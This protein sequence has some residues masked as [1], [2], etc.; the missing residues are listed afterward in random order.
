MVSIRAKI[1]A[2]RTHQQA[3]RK[4]Q[5][6]Q[7]F[8]QVLENDPTQCDA[9]Q[10]YGLRAFEQGA[11]AE[12]ADLL[13]RAVKSAPSNAYMR[14]N[15]GAAL[16]S[17]GRIEDAIA[18]YKQALAINPGL[19][20]THNNLA[21]AYRRQGLVAE[22]IEH[23]QRAVHLRPDYA[24][25]HSNLGNALRAVGRLNEALACQ[26]RTVALR[27]DYA[28][29]HNNL[30]LAQSSL[31]DF[32]GSLASLRRAIEL[33][34]RYGEA[35]DSLGTTLRR[36]GRDDEAAAA[37]RKAI[38]LDP[39]FAA[40]HNNLGALIHA[41]GRAAEAVPCYRSALEL[42][43]NHALARQNLADAL[44]E[45]GDHRE[46]MDN[47][48]I[49]T[50]L[51][52]N[53]RLRLVTATMLPP[54][55]ES[56]AEMQ[57]W[58]ERVGAQLTALAASP[59]ALNPDIDTLPSLFYLAYLGDRV[60]P[61]VEAAARCYRPQL[62]QLQV[63]PG[64]PGASRPLR[65]GFVSRLFKNHTI[66][67]LM[68]G[69]IAELGRPQFD[70]TVI[71]RG[72]YDD[73]I[74]RFIREKADRY[75]EI[76]EH[77]TSAIQIVRE[78]RLDV[79]FYAD[80]GMDPLVSSLAYHRL[81]PTQ[82]VTWGHPVTT[83]SPALDYFVSSDLIEP[84][85]AETEYTERLVRMP[86]LPAY[87]YRPTLRGPRK[88]RAS[89]GLAD[90]EHVYCCPQ[91]LF[92]FHPEFDPLLAG[93]LRRDPQGRIVLVA[94][95]QPQWNVTLA[96]RLRNTMP[97]V[98]GRITI[99]PRQSTDD[100]LHLLAATDV[101]LDPLHF[102]GGN[103]AYEGLGLGIPIVT[104]PG[105]YMRGRV[106]LG[107]YRQMGVSDCVVDSPEEYVDLAVRLGTDGELRRAVSGEILASRHDLFEDRQAVDDLESFLLK[108]AAERRA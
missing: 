68:Q 98:C 89:F 24:E 105:R 92:K 74:G 107:C 19:P 57:T 23:G 97:D 62:R 18:C 42:E 20:H 36:L 48:E 8:R 50:R 14:T 85:A 72:R 104:L 100:F 2:A 3:G 53:P 82:C 99:V 86:R 13:T 33:N 108:A 61:L 88:D 30:G 51:S 6:E 76:P 17:L 102:G 7:L 26:V 95:S 12:A 52:P 38:E 10:Y 84:W 21:V 1:D 67:R 34:P 25:A 46:A 78:L 59:V 80:V 28:E 79:L 40:A 31:G 65:I 5:A 73:E 27:P 64:T 106:T 11:F 15:L 103:T 45:L 41:A 56:A 37:Y 22:A 77:L 54:V 63:E 69:F 96:Q 44:H 32:E 66:G 35:Y 9:L 75:V 83:A 94:A 47:Y 101:L 29:G 93:I 58:R 91:S 43:P 39:R 81:A 55:Y 49:A 16:Q 71:S 87:Y 70:V 4:A 90:D 60:R